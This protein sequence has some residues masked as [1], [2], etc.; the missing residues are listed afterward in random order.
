MIIRFRLQRAR[1][2]AGSAEF[3]EMNIFGQQLQEV[4]DN[5]A[6][7]T[8]STIE[9]WQS[10]SPAAGAQDKAFPRGIRDTGVKRL[11]GRAVSSKH[12]PSCPKCHDEVAQ[13]LWDFRVSSKA[14]KVA[15]V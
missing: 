3:T 4:D 5:I 14:S 8:V 9:G 1:V 12:G 10:A 15:R 2:V 7:I 6:P 11:R 13:Q